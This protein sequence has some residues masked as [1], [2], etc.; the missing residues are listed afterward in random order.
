MA[1]TEVT[2]PPHQGIFSIQEEGSSQSQ[3]MSH[4]TN[5]FSSF[6][7]IFWSV[8]GRLLCPQCLA[9]SAQPHWLLEQG[10]L[11]I[12]ASYT[13]RGG[14]RLFSIWE[15]LRVFDI[16]TLML[17]CHHSGSQSDTII[18]NKSWLPDS[19]LTSTRA[20]QSHPCPFPTAR[21]GKIFLLQG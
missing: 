18:E 4:I 3:F 5:S 2:D 16:W 21:A 20:H 6:V 14:Q 7:W 13:H 10:T 9:G 11:H 19:E 1:P 12:L 17:K 8:Q 15:T